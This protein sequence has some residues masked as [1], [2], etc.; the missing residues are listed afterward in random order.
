LPANNARRQLLTE[1]YREALTEIVPDV[2]MPFSSAKGQSA[3]HILPILLPENAN[4]LAFMDEMK[5]Q[6]I[7]TSIHY[8]PIHTFKA[9]REIGYSFHDLSVTENIAAREV[10]LPLYPG[11]TEDNLMLVVDTVRKSLKISRN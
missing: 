1:L 10:T 9:F 11:M 2:R 7:Q 5:A 6:G 3:Y 4:R 8:P